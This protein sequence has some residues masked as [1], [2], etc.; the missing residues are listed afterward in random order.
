[1]CKLWEN[2][3]YG[4]VNATFYI[5]CARVLPGDE[6]YRDISTSMSQIFC[7]YIYSA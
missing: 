5:L 3:H 1:M 7:V 4:N 6:S 2:L